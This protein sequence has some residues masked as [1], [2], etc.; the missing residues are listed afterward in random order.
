MLTVEKQ[1]V[2]GWAKSASVVEKHGCCPDTKCDCCGGHRSFTVLRSKGLEMTKAVAESALQSK[3]LT[4]ARPL[5]PPKR[6]FNTNQKG[7]SRK[8]PLQSKNLAGRRVQY[9]PE[10][11][12]Y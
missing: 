8:V 12:A 3:N 5:N 11:T 9:Q 4:G 10:T 7:V 2:G 1:Q 6:D